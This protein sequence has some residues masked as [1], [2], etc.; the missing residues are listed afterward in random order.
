[1]IRRMFIASLF[2]LGLAAAPARADAPLTIP[3]ARTVDA[4]AIVALIETRPDLVIF[5]NRRAEDYANGFIEGA[6]R[7]LD[8]DL[9]EAFLAGHLRTKDTPVLFY[10]NGLR[11]GRAAK[12]AEMAVR[13]GYTQVHYYALGMEEWRAL[14]LPLSGP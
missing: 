8:T 9:T 2:A 1:M 13:W 10:C 3:G 12:A 5:D 6:I 7:V 11:C 14:G 4:R